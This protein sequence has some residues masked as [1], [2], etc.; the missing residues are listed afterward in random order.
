MNKEEI[1]AKIKADV[2]RH[3]MLISH[4]HK[5]PESYEVGYKEG[6]AYAVNEIY[7]LLANRNNK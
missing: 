1:I 7:K 6:V 2:E 4:F 5:C 3:N